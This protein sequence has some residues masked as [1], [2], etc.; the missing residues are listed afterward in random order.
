MRRDGSID[1]RVLAGRLGVYL[2]ASS[3]AAALARSLVAVNPINVTFVPELPAL[4]AV[5]S[6]DP[7]TAAQIQMLAE[8]KSARRLILLTLLLTRHCF[9]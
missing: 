8:R 5:G 4:V 9:S 3:L 6:Q 1:F 7:A 2:G